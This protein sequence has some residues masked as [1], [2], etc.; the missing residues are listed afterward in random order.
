MSC[1]LAAARSITCE[2][3]TCSAY[4]LLTTEY[5]SI[6]SGL[7]TSRNTHNGQL[8]SSEGFLHSPSFLPTFRG[9]P[10]S[11]KRID[12]L[13]SLENKLIQRGEVCSNYERYL[14][15]SPRS[16]DSLDRY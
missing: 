4:F 2:Q 10:R 9:R 14:S 7:T 11:F 8:T 12:P 1:L 6:N 3:P 5:F 13:E 15:S 16:S